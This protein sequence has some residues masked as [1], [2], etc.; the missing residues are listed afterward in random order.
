MKRNT[1]F[2]IVFIFSTLLTSCLSDDFL[3]EN[4][5][6][7]ISADNL[8][9]DF[10]GFES[11]LNGL[12]ALAV[13]E[14]AYEGDNAN[15]CYNTMMVQ[16]MDNM[17]SPRW[18]GISQAMNE[19]DGK[20]TSQIGQI[21]LTWEWLYQIINASNTIIERA[22]N[23]NIDWMT[24]SP[25]E[26]LAR[27]NKVVAE[28]RFFRAWAYRHLTN[29]WNN[30]PLNLNESKGDM[31]DNKW[32]PT[33]RSEVEKQMESDWLFAAEHLPF[34]A[35]IPGRV[36]SAVA[37]HYLAEL[38]IIWK[39]YNMAEEFAK[40]VTSRSE[41][42]LITNRYGVKKNK[43]GTPFTDMFIDGNVNRHEG[44]TE[45]L[46]V[47]QHEYLVAGGDVWSRM[48]RWYTFPYWYPF[49]GVTLA[50]TIDRGGRGLSAG[51]ITSWAIDNFGNHDD[52]GSEYALRKFYII[53]EGDKI[54][55]TTYKIGDTLKLQWGRNLEIMNQV[56]WP[57]ITKYDW[58]HPD[59]VSSGRSYKDEPYIR[60]AETYLLLAEAQIKQGKLT[61]AAATINILRK[62][63]NAP[64]I[65]SSIIDI[66]FL[67]DERSRELFLEEHRRYVLV[68][69]GKYA[70]RV[71]KY[72]GTT[73]GN[74]LD[75]YAYFPI[76]QPVIDENPDYPQ[77]EGW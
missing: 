57:S 43:P 14:H 9:T 16:G 41:Y 55:G 32:M 40:K 52:R 15:Y 21:R 53:G 19:Y 67:L 74:V 33:P 29:L 59:N 2:Y 77:N 30:V 54:T 7:L 34:V 51:A 64:E 44:N 37:Y 42:Q 6:D 49:K 12:N 35:E 60:L 18:G 45:V 61:E 5:K 3:D 17:W 27:K 72:N 50:I 11:A 31:I 13:K 69:N 10:K 20:L 48:I 1:I 8:F 26:A 66:D 36:S 68:R 63:A 58:A 70:E 22:E 47:F 62:R 28:A 24:N 75:K 73:L 65:S 38:Y 23:Q 71:N 39:D 25:I 46:W 56:G 76:P 4:I